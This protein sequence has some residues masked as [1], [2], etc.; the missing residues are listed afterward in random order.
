[1]SAATDGKLS[2]AMSGGDAAS[3]LGM[4][5]LSLRTLS[6]EAL[7]LNLGLRESTGDLPMTMASTWF[8]SP[9]SLTREEV[10]SSNLSTILPSPL[11]LTESSSAQ[12]FSDGL[13]LSLGNAFSNDAGDILSS[14]SAA[15]SKLVSLAVW[16]LLSPSFMSSSAS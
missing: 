8:L 10:D 15:V 3:A 7:E 16:T 13:K 1:M 12:L 9:L 6:S 11:G 5:M 2:S 14:S 4:N